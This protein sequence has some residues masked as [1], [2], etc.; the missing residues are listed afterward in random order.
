MKQSYWRH[1]VIV[2]V[3]FAFLY[4]FAQREFMVASL[5]FPLGMVAF[6]ALPRVRGHEPRGLHRI[7][8]RG[9]GWLLI[10]LVGLTITLL[11]ALLVLGRFDRSQLWSGLFGVCYL[12]FTAHLFTAAVEQTGVDATQAPTPGGSDRRGHIGDNRD[13]FAGAPTPLDTALKIIRAEIQDGCRDGVVVGGLATYLANLRREIDALTSDPDMH[14]LASYL[15]AWLSN[16]RELDTDA[17]LKAGNPR[18]RPHSGIG[19]E[20]LLDGRTE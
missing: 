15:E 19:A 5:I 8:R 10:T 11:V 14:I 2:A 7:I 4:A 1:A 3:V 9:V 13:A 20:A 6:G 12:I 18:S 17:R 16:Y